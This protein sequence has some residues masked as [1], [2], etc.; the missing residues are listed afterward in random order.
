METIYKGF[1]GKAGLFQE[2]VEA[3]VAGGVARAER[4]VEGRPAIKAVIEEPDPIR[5][6]ELYAATQPGIH[7]RAGPLLR[8]LR[9]AAAVDADLVGLLQRIE[10]QR[11]E[12]MS[13]FCPTSP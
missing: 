6:L 8:T 12:G 13:R 11:L 3:A 2:V 1:A 4:P 10:S 9:E 5:K 7:N